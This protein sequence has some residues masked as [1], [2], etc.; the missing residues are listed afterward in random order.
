[1]FLNFG[2]SHEEPRWSAGRTAD[3][4]WWSTHTLSLLLG[5]L[6]LEA[7][8]SGRK[9]KVYGRLTFINLLPFNRDQMREGET[10]KGSEEVSTAWLFLRLDIVTVCSAPV[11][12]PGQTT[13]VVLNKWPVLSSHWTSSLSMS[14][15]DLWEHKTLLGTWHFKSWV[16]DGVM[17]SDG[18]LFEQSCLDQCWLVGTV[19][20][21]TSITMVS[22]IPQLQVYKSVFLLTP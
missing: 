8:D 4:D 5:A 22:L 18:S 3:R 20:G 10:R 9:R 14:Q 11:P 13:S 15:N 17:P 21:N 2:W 12:H 7:Q 1:M 19:I 6:F 16:W